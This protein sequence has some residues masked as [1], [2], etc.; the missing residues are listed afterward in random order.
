LKNKIK[1][2]LCFSAFF[3]IFIFILADVLPKFT[4][5]PTALFAKAKKHKVAKNKK[6]FFICIVLIDEKYVLF[7]WNEIKIS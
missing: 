4:V 5:C 3:D 7:L 2:R 6:V 1:I